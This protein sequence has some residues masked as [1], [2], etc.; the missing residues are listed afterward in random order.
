MLSRLYI[1][2]AMTIAIY[3]YSNDSSYKHFDIGNEYYAL[4]NY[5]SALIEYNKVFDS[6]MISKE[7]YL[8]IG[9]CYFKLDS[10]P[11]AIL[12]YEKGLK[13]APADADLT[14][15]LQYCNQLIKDKNPIK[16]S[17]LLNEL[18][19][20]FLGKSPNYWAYAS[21]LLMTLTCILILLFKI[22]IEP[23]WKKINFY[24]AVFVSILFSIT[25]LLAYISKS[26]MNETKYGIVIETST[27]VRTEPS[28]N[29]STAFLLHEGSKAKV[30]AKINEWLEISFND[31]KGWIKRNSLEKI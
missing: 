13:L 31:K 28:E 12:Y 11:Q 7:L 3:G 19:F 4:K 20:S 27:K 10:I 14:Y 21:V 18:I 15:N 25:I 30:T 23:K 24:T 17:V 8:N 9:N 22:S 6:K 26:K 29:A 16:K 2:L 5:D 1:I